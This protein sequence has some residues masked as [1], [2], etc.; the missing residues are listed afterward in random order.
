VAFDNKA[1][2]DQQEYLTLRQENSNDEKL[3]QYDYDQAAT[4]S[5]RSANP[6]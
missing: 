4:S 6:E 3:D 1:I 2:N 5:N